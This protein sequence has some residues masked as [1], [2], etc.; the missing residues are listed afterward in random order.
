MLAGAYKRL[1]HQTVQECFELRVLYDHVSGHREKD[2]NLEPTWRQLQDRKVTAVYQRRKKAVG[3]T[4]EHATAVTI[5][6]F[7]DMIH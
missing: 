3:Q 1:N 6:S 4:K 7:Y 5:E 2:S